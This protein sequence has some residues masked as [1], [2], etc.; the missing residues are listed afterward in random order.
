MNNLNN[1]LSSPSNV[2]SSPR[3]RLL[4]PKKP[5]SPRSLKPK[6][7][8]IKTVVQEEEQNQQ[9]KCRREVNLDIDENLGA[10]PIRWNE[11]EVSASPLNS[12]SVS[13]SPLPLLS[14]NLVNRR[15]GNSSPVNWSVVSALVDL[16]QTPT[17]QPLNL[18]TSGN[19][20]FAR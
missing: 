5:Q 17:P 1:I 20:H 15:G 6:K 9:I 2:L 13:S 14:G 18:S 16:G 12:T 10:M 7:R 3:R 19:R 11:N 8:W 4:S